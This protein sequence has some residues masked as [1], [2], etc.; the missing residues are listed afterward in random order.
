MPQ[1]ISFQCKITNPTGRTLVTSYIHGVLNQIDPEKPQ[2]RSLIEKLQ[3]LVEG[4]IRTI[5][6]SASDAYGLY[7]PSKIVFFSRKNLAKNIREGEFIN[8]KNRDESEHLYRIV[9][10]QKNMATLDGNHPLAGQDLTFEI[11]ALKVRKA[12]SAEQ[13]SRLNSLSHSRLH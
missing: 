8:L 10:L 5:H 6:L 9:S 3:D 4:E 13:D 12:D 2:F 11:T 7:D 1:I